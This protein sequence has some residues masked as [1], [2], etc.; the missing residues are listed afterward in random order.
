[1]EGEHEIPLQRILVGLDASPSSLTALDAA[2]ELAGALGI[3]LRGL[4]VEDVN[5]LRVAE[6]PSA[7][8]L[9]SFS[10]KPLPLERR[11]LEGGLRAEARKARKALA[12]VAESGLL[13]WSFHV[14]RG[15][16]APEILAAAEAN[17]VVVGKSGWSGSRVGSTARAVAVSAPGPALIV[18]RETR[19]G[20]TVVVLYDGSAAAQRALVLAASLTRKRDMTIVFPKDGSQDIKSLVA[21]AERWLAEHGV[22][23]NSFELTSGDLSALARLVNREEASLLLVPGDTSAGRE[24]ALAGLVEEI[25]RPVLFIR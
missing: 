25:E 16:V 6:L 20:S 18:G 21:Q 1:V 11:H 5:L 24:A 12:A 9:G 2:A 10:G 13:R 19:P 22:P 3:E 15:V 14:A 7:R 17:L 8:V 23:A 4:F